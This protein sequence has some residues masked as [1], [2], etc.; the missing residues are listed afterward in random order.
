MGTSDARELAHTAKL[1]SKHLQAAI[2]HI[3]KIYNPGGEQDR[4]QPLFILSAGWR[5]GST[6]L[7]RLVSSK[8]STPTIVWGEPYDLCNL[9]QRLSNS[10]TP[11]GQNWPPSSYYAAKS[12]LGHLEKTW[13]ANLYPPLDA[14]WHAHR[15]FF[16][17]LYACTASDL[18]FT[19]WGLKEVR[20]T[21]D[22]ARYLLWLFPNARF[23]FI[24]RNP[25][26]AFR[27]YRSMD[28]TWFSDWPDNPMLTPTQF[29]RHWKNLVSGFLSDNLA[30][31]SLTIR[32]EDLTGSK[33]IRTVRKIEDFLGFA[34]DHQ[35]LEFRIPGGVTN[36]NPWIS[37]LD[38]ALIRRTTSPIS[39]ELGY[40]T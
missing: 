32:F 18:G 9:V 31:R 36:R 16:E 3:E 37:K 39:R 28:A 27:S 10:L 15:Q 17:Q 26:D 22:H 13:I 4:Q 29:G 25:E 7:Q 24:Y 21:I 40:F 2:Q 30:G 33:N 14:L 38:R 11:F 19:N 6:L 35:A 12:H 34:L 8:S 1:Q 23:L 20:L 5:S